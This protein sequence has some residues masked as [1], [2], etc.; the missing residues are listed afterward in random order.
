MN[1]F[2][3]NHILKASLREENLEITVNTVKYILNDWIFEIAEIGFKF[4]L[5]VTPTNKDA[6]EVG[7]WK[8]QNNSTYPVFKVFR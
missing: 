6:H 2:V 3:Q 7:T 1:F 4:T 5:T 8:P